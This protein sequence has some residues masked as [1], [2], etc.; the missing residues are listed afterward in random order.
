L[1]SEQSKLLRGFF[2]DGSFFG[3]FG[4]KNRI[5]KL[6][7]IFLK[8]PELVLELDGLWMYVSVELAWK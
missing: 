1:L 6:D 7:F 4:L 3:T 8:R 5:E 2:A